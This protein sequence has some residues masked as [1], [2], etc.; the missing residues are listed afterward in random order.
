[1][2][3][4]VIATTFN[5]SKEIPLFMEDMLNQ[6]LSPNEIIVVDGGSKDNTVSILEKIKSENRSK[7]TIT[8]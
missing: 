3:Y 6:T 4:S 5:D 1:M 8:I 7:I 2:T